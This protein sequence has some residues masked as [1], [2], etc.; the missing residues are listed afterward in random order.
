[1]ALGC[2]MDYAVDFI[3][4]YYA[5]HLVEVGYV[6]LHECVVGPV[7]DVLQVGEVAGIGQLVEVYDSIIG[8]FVYKQAHDMASD[9]AG[10]SGY[11]DVTLHFLLCLR[12]I[13]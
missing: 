6:G 10:A 9:K 2:E 5:A 13:S 8:I 3:L 1:M 7:L 4:P 11:K 12:C